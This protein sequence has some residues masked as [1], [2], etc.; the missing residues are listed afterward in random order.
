V[1][2]DEPGPDCVELVFRGFY[3]V[4]PSGEVALEDYAR[5]VAAARAASVLAAEDGRVRGVHLCAPGLATAALREDVEAF[6][7]ELAGRGGGGLGW[8]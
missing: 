2:R 7:R 6:A 3:S 5:E 1:S 4:A 8:S